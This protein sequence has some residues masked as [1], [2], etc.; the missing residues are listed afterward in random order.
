M[1]Q[2][3][4][5]IVAL[6]V[7]TPRKALDL[8]KR[9]YGLVN[10]VK[11]GLELFLAGG[12]S[13]IAACKDMELQVFLDLKFMDIPNTVQAAVAQ[14]TAMD[15][16]MLTIHCL[17]GRAMAKAALAGRDQS[18]RSGQVP[19]LVLGVT[20][21]TSL[22]P[23]DL[24]WHPQGTADDLRALTVDLARS[25]Q[26]WGLDGVVCSGQEIL[27]IRQLCPEPFSLLTPGI[28]MS[29]AQAGDQTRVVTPAQ[30]ARD[31]SSYLVVGRPI[32]RAVDPVRAARSYLT[33]IQQSF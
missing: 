4:Q 17:G 20:I 25:A 23:A 6:D 8:A 14:A 7:P 9:L 5:L 10:W 13:F 32:T 31:G 1:N 3:P 24:V 11:V 33:E 22:G 15:V 27:A 2:P 18:A 26:N 19:P 28:R 21:L 16:D 29:D 30:A 12:Q